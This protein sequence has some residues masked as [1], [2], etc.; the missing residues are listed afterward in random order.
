MS[1]RRINTIGHRIGQMALFFFSLI[2]ELMMTTPNALGQERSRASNAKEIADR[3]FEWFKKM[4]GRSVDDYLRQIRP[5]KVSASFK[6]AVVANSSA[7]EQVRLSSAMRSRLAALQSVLRFHDRADMVEIKVINVNYAY[8]GFQARTVLLISE[9]AFD[10]LS[11]KELQAVVAHE[12]GHEYFWEEIIEARRN[13]DFELMREIEMRCDG[14]AVLTLAR[15]GIDPV[16]LISAISRIYAINLNAMSA[17]S[18]QYPPPDQRL[19]FIRRMIEQARA[20]RTAHEYL[21]LK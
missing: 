11:E 13:K 20:E 2:C 5:G 3:A 7:G 8:V 4:E 15:L 10:V 9:K 19:N 18:F 1:T 17:N 6:A 21:S 12:L 14:I 16:N